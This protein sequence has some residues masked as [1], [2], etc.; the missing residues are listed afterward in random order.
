MEAAEAIGGLFISFYESAALNPARPKLF[1]EI[2]F[3]PPVARPNRS[4][5]LC[6][7]TVGDNANR[8]SRIAGK[9]QGG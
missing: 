8:T 9:Q 1:R 3:G 4:D 6:A 2:S 5:R 7:F